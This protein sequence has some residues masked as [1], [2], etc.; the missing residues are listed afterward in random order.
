VR[1]YENE[2]QSINVASI[3]IQANADIQAPGSWEQENFRR[4][5]R[6]PKNI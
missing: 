5:I 1:Q 2:S 3:E 4:E 6:V